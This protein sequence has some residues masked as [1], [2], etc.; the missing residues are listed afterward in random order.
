MDKDGFVSGQLPPEVPNA[1]NSQQITAAGYDVVVFLDD[2][3]E[4]TKRPD[5]TH[6][7]T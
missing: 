3:P 7:R 4:L 1:D 2:R 6:K 5:L